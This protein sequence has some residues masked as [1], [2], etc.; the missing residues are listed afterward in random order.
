[1]AVE[2]YVKIIVN[3][4]IP[5]WVPVTIWNKKKFIEASCTSNTHTVEKLYLE[6]FW[7]VSFQTENTKLHYTSVCM[8]LI[9]VS[10]EEKTKWILFMRSKFIFLHVDSKFDVWKFKFLKESSSLKYWGF[11]HLFLWWTQK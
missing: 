6:D 9:W 11:F 5:V 1:M 3:L 8:R 10:R 2:N 4:Y 7:V